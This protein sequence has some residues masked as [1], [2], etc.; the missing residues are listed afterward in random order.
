[1]TSS[2]LPGSRPDGHRARL[3]SP[4]SLHGAGS[5]GPYLHSVDERLLAA[6]D[7]ATVIARRYAPTMLRGSLALIFCWFGALK[8][9]GSSPVYAL[10]GDTLPWFDPRLIVPVVGAVEVLLGIGLLVPRARRLVLV[11]LVG[12]LCGTFLT[13]LMSPASMFRGADPLML[14][15]SGEFVLKNLVLIS[16][17]LVLLGTTASTE[18][19]GR[20][21]WSG[22]PRPE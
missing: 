10:I 13:F 21:S 11:A 3:V 7:Q 9:I 16:A 8:V 15:S 18:P 17:V 5:L 19:G 20:T 22:R 14:T 4:L 12:H 6:L 1:M 2:T